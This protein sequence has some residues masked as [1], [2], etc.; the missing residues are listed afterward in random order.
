MYGLEEVAT[1]SNHSR[2]TLKWIFVSLF[3]SVY[4]WL[5]ICRSTLSLDLLLYVESLPFRHAARTSLRWLQIPHACLRL[6]CISLVFLLLS[7]VVFVFRKNQPL[8]IVAFW[9]TH[10]RIVLLSRWVFETS[11]Y[12]NVPE[13][14]RLKDWGLVLYFVVIIWLLDFKVL[15][16]L[17]EVVISVIQGLVNS[18]AFLCTKKHVL[19][20]LGTESLFCILLS[21]F[22]QLKKV[23]SSHIRGGIT[24]IRIQGRRLVLILI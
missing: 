10:Q 3:C 6:K 2:L 22:L 5:V 16:N 9:F 12:V 19:E 21:L 1:T 4:I 24:L 14:H 23:W 17:L 7:H 15:D 13:F 20:F 8:S 18:H 11:G